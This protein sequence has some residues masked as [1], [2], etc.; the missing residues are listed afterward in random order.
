MAALDTLPLALRFR[1]I[2]GTTG[3][4]K[5]RL[6][7]ALA[8]SG[9][10]VLDLEALACHRGSVLGGLPLQPQPG[11][12]AFETQ[13]WNVLRRCDPARPVFVESESRK[14]GN[15]RVPD[16]LLGK[17]RESDCI[18]LDVAARR[19]SPTAAR[20]V[21]ALRTRAG[22][23]CDPARL[24][25]AAARSRESQRL[26]V[27]GAGAV[28]GRDGRA[29]LARALRSS[30]PAVDCTEL[31]RVIT[32]ARAP[33][34]IGR[35]GRLRSGR[36]RTRGLSGYF[37]AA[38]AGAPAALAA[39]LPKSGCRIFTLWRSRS[40]SAY[41]TSSAAAAWRATALRSASRCAGWPAA[42]VFARQDVSDQVARPFDVGADVGAA[43]C[44][45]ACAG[46]PPAAW[47]AC[48]AARGAK[49]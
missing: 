22:H 25:R 19:A 26:E 29:T 41:A 5:S 27:T 6:L 45:T 16:A 17:M 48:S 1:V 40:P 14:I 8:S 28:V 11:Q 10:Q 12:K 30:L 47:A 49:R 39:S 36:T 37:F 24:P 7:Q 15:L 38:S 9:A 43:A 32:G 23:A 20:R 46:P 3:S 4:G 42:P 2:C 13:L 21:R 33:D 44:R 18:R 35:S 34:R 31:P